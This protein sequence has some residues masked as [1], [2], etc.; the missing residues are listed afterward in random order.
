[1]LERPSFPRTRRSPAPAGRSA[2]ACEAGT[3]P[4]TQDLAS[5]RAAAALVTPP[6]RER[7]LGRRPSDV[8]SPASAFAAQ[9]VPWLL[10]V[11]GGAGV[12]SLVRC[13]VAGADAERVWPCQGL[14]VLV[15][16]RTS[17]GLEWARDAARQHASGGAPAGAALAGLAVVADAPG[18]TPPRVGRFLN[19]ICGAFPRV[20]EVPW[21]EEWRLA[22]YAEPLPAPPAARQLDK[23]LQALSGAR[24]SQETE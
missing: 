13:G 4:G 20:W 2:P 8:R 24:T 18:C 23:D 1:M 5:E 22:G 9:N 17:Y 11:H 19:L 14:V 10:G 12:T 21:V 7:Q 16:R 6:S 15:S 3:L